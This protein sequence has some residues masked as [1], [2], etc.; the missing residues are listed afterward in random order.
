M[1]TKTLTNKKNKNNKQQEQAQELVTIILLCDS[2]GYR[3]K[4]YGPISLIEINNTKLID[5]QINTIKNLFKNFELIVCLG[6]DCEKV[7]THIRTKYAKD[8]NI[9]IV[10]NQLYHSSNSCESLRL[11]L[12]NTTNTRIL[13][14]DGNLVL[15]KNSLQ[16]IN[17]NKSCALFEKNPC[18][19]LEVGFN[20]NESDI[21]KHF[22]YGAK[23]IWSEI[24]FLNG[25]SIVESLRKIIVE[26]DSKTRFIFEAI[27]E[28]IKMRYEMKA[29]SNPHQIIKINNIKTYHN[30]KD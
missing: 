2:P 20:K 29:I 3:M 9:R 13:V 1:K 21:I 14:C 24:F 4:S 11:C 12:N 23:N 10:E 5:L 15:S 7:C 22:S 16:L 26:Y 17:I 30:M 28:L 25:Y 19:N 8:I 6:F 27:N 18:Q